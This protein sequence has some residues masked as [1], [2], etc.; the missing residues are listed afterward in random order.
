MC[1]HAYVYILSG[2][3]NELNIVDEEL[4]RLNFAR[5]NSDLEVEGVWNVQLRVIDFYP[6]A[7]GNGVPNYNVVQQELDHWI[8]QARSWN[9]KHPCRSLCHAQTTI[10]GGGG[11]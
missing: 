10:K 3:Q 4:H 11:H 5:Y 7:T 6:Q 1:M 9:R 8:R 2:N